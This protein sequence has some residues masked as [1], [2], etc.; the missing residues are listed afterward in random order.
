M[1]NILSSNCITEYLTIAH[2]YFYFYFFQEDNEPTDHAH[3]M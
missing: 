3:I 1:H 2:K